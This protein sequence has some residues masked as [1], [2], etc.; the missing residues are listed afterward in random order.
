M[1]LRHLVA[2]A[3]TLGLVALSGPAF[4]AGPP[5]TVTVGGATSGTFSVSAASSG[6]VVF[7]AKNNA[8]TVVNMNCT[9]V[10]GTGSVVAGTNKNPVATITSTTWTG[11]RIPGGAATVTQA[12][13]WNISGTGSNATAGTETIAG[14]VNNVTAGVA[15]TASPSVCSFTVTGQADGAFNEAT[16]QL[17]INETG[18]SGDLVLSGVGPCLGQ[19][20]SGNFADMQATLNVSSSGGAIN[21]S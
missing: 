9:A 14:N 15:L 18:Y 1:K 17:V 5:Y 11:C 19:L 10:S 2:G 7:T 13:T 6:P 8:G 21:L 4:A 20:Q 12:G 3:A 16:Q